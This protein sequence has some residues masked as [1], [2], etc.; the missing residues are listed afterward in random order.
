MFILQEGNGYL[1]TTS[2]FTALVCPKTV[3]VAF[4]VGRNKG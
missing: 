2:F 1:N 3:Y 4:R